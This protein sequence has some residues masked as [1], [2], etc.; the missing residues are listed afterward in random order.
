MSKLEV[1]DS[2]SAARG[3]QW[4]A[5]R[6]CALTLLAI[7]FLDEL[8]DGSWQAA[9]PLI[10]DDLALSYVQIGLLLS[11]P[12]FVGN[13]LEPAV[14]ILGDT[15]RRRALILAGGVGYTLALLLVAA[16]CG[17]VS[18]LL[19]FIAFNP[20]SGAFVGLAQAALMD[21]DTTRREQNMA[22]WV[23][24]GSLGVVCG[25]LAVNAAVALGAGWRGWYGTLAL[26]TLALLFAARRLKLTHAGADD[27]QAHVGFIS[28]ARGALRELRRVEVLRWLVLLELADLILD[29]LHGFLA[30]YFADVAGLGATRAGLVVAVLS[31]VGLLGD[32]LLIPLLERVRGL[33]YLRW[34]AL[35]MLCVFPAF[36]VVPGTTAKLAL[37]AL[38]GLAN[39]GWYPIL[40]AQLYAA[41]PGRSG[42]AL[43]LANV[44]GLLGA[45]IPYGLGLYAQRFG[46]AAM[47]WLLLVGPVAL[48]VCAGP[49]GGKNSPDVLG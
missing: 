21:A 31:G 33:R 25:A 47:M 35:A 7:E 5:L 23:F 22:R 44:A 42:A 6:A 29:G 30:L 24:A 9:C 28:N 18:L 10:R 37:V 27:A 14:F 15:R 39:T 40:K 43:A 4:T 3:R 26:L 45:L 32:L 2:A 12:K 8:A 13:L 16:S 49:R 17:F 48:L 1:S 38:V 46:L 19:A 11:V 41:L 34:S 20:A 36:L